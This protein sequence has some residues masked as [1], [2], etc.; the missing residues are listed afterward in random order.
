MAAPGDHRNVVPEQIARLLD[1]QEMLLTAQISLASPFPIAG[2]INLFDRQAGVEEMS[3][4]GLRPGWLFYVASM[5]VEH[6]GS[7]LIVFNRLTWLGASERGF[8]TLIA[9]CLGR[10]FWELNGASSVVQLNSFLEHAAIWAAFILVTVVAQRDG[11]PSRR[12][13]C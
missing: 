5:V 6:G 1:N 8:F 11:W 13:L 9:T 10:R 3:L 12:T 2:T 7:V 4:L